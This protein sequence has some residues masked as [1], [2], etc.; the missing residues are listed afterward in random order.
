VDQLG[1]GVRKELGRFGPQAEIGRLAEVWAAAVG[2]QIARNAWPARVTRDGT[3]HVHTSSSAWAFVLQQL[4]DD[5]RARLGELAPTK[6]RFAPGPLPEAPPPTADEA[7][8]HAP[9]PTA[10]DT[11]RAAELAAPIDDENLRNL[12]ARAAAA[13]LAKHAE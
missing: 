10:E 1:D 8:A 6:L 2:E 12:V 5:I 11:R 13:S 9:A 7:A 4:E 3:L